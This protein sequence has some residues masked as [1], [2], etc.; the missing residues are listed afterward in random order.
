MNYDQFDPRNQKDV[1]MAQKFN[2][3][4][5]YIEKTSYKETFMRLMYILSSVLSLQI[6]LPTS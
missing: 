6:I 1:Y 5:L 4:V 3:Y 2:F